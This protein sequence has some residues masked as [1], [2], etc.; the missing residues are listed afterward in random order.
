M[1][2]KHL[3]PVCEIIAAEQTP[4]LTFLS[5]HNSPLLAAGGSFL[6]F[7]LPEFRSINYGFPSF[8]V[9]MSISPNLTIGANVIGSHWIDD[10]IQT[11]GPF[12]NTVWG[13][14]EKSMNAGFHFHNLKGP[15]DFHLTDVSFDVSRISRSPKWILGYGVTAHYFKTYLHVTDH[16]DSTQNYKLT[17]DLNCLFFRYGIYRR[18]GKTMQLG[19]EFFLT[20]GNFISNFNVTFNF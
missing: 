15:D 20:T 2:K 19:G 1:A 17:T 7:A 9:A 16:Q 4:L 6:T 8:W 13:T 11:I 18:I 10:N 12:L 3:E 5:Y 14:Q